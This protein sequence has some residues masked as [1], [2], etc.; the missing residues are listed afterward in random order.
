MQNVTSDQAEL[1]ASASDRT[2]LGGVREVA[3]LAFPVI[4]TQLS[5]TA[6]GVTDAA[7]VGRLGAVELAAVGFAGIWAWTFF[8]LF[9]GTATGVQTFVSQ[10]DG[11]GEYESCG[12]WAWQAAYILV[13]LSGLAVVALQLW[14]GPFLELL[15]PSVALRETALE[16]FEPRLWGTPG[17]VIGVIVASFFR[18]F[19]DTRTP[20]YATLAANAVNVVLDYGLIFGELGLPRWGVA[21]AG[22]ATGVGEW[23]YAAYLIV[24][25]QRRRV[26]RRH[27]TRPV[28][29][30]PG[31]IRRFLRVGLPVG[32]EWMVGMSSF[33]V[34]STL[35]ARMGDTAMAASQGFLMLLSLS[36]MQAIGISIAAS[37]MVGRYI[38]AQNLPAARRS[39]WS[40][41]K[42]A[43]I[44]GGL[45][46][47]LFVSIPGT[48]MRLFTDDPTVIQLGRSLVI[49]GAA[50]QLFDAFGIVAGGA[51]RGAGDTRWP[52]LVHTGFAWG[53]FVPAAWLLGIWLDG[54]LWGAWLAG[55]LYVIA[56]T[57]VFVLRFKSGAW[58]RMQI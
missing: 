47:V 34:F 11:A 3:A 45:V 40:A 37:T 12:R 42:L 19:G 57:L 5:R 20:L 54:G 4:L 31:E 8:C 25:F 48:L 13:P 29:P 30:N 49:L 2:A 14:A 51:L 16:Y 7:M 46:A 56:M 38:G 53:L 39:F 15:G 17:F 52:F 21:G 9:F 24:A 1:S 41:Q 50:F 35:I 10:H 26:A 33:A 58:E 44:L 55:T 43:L 22:L 28:A 23:T 36:F 32:A 6:M 18:G 27:L